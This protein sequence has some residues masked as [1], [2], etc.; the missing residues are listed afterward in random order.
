MN[1]AVLIILIFLSS[2]LII[3]CAKQEISQEQIQ[4]SAMKA[5]SPDFSQGSAIPK[6]FTCDGADVSPE[7]DIENLPEDTKSIAIIIDDPDAASGTFTHWIVWNIQPA[8]K[9]EKNSG[10]GISGTNS[11]KKTGYQG[12]CPP[13]GKA[14]RYIF[15]IHA[16][17]A[18]LDLQL[19]AAKSDLINT[20]R[21]HV[22]AQSELTGIYSR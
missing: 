1:A 17:D 14:H 22:L 3:G 8:N 7:L 12:P 9:I 4:A 21:G 20:M 10:Q 18:E 13:S 6:E 16:L 5:T 11:F 2:F 19:S 15:K